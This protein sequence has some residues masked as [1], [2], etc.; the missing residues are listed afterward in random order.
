MS[1]M[2]QFIPSPAEGPVDYFQSST[3]ISEAALNICVQD[4]ENMF[5]I[6]LGKYPG[7]ESLIMR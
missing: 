6:L 7:V 2:K 1:W 5:L 4:F 3:V